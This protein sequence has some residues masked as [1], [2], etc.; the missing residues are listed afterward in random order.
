MQANQICNQLL[1]CNGNVVQ[2]SLIAPG[3]MLQSDLSGQADVPP[4]QPSLV[5]G[6]PRSLTTPSTIPD[7]GSNGQK[8]LP[9]SSAGA[10]NN[11]PYRAML[12]Q[13]QGA[14]T[15][16]SIASGFSALGGN[17]SRRSL[18]QQVKINKHGISGGFGQVDFGA[19]SG[20]RNRFQRYA[21]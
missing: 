2:S 12:K 11:L 15:D 10:V 16:V 21:W 20:A 4:S 14:L 13:N 18:R 6:Q 19:S 7:Y 9:F 3:E 17:T 5:S 1:S 8:Q